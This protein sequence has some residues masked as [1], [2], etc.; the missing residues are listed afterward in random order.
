MPI[1]VPQDLPASE[2]L[3]SEN[4]FV[5]DEER[6]R[7]QDIRPLKLGIINLMPTKISTETQLLRRVSNMALQIHVDLIRTGTYESTHTSREHLQKFY[8]TLEQVKDKK[9]DALIV[10]GA[11]VEH[12]PYEDVAYWDEMVEVM[13]WARRNVFSTMFICWA[14]QAALYH[15]YGIPKYGLDE[16]LFGVFKGYMREDSILTS[17]FDDAFY[18]PHSRVAYNK[19]EDI[20]QIEDLSILVSS[21]EAGA[22]ITATRDNRLI[23]VSGHGEYDETTLEDEYKRDLAK[24]IDIAPPANYY[25]DDDPAKGI[26]KRWTAHSNLLFSNWLNYCV[27][28]ETPFNIEEIT[29]KEI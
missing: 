29:E 2:V 12:M 26:M 6:A 25:H 15:Y 1:V 10:T 8:V 14:A 3:A 4:I 17:G 20:G 19:S 16:K 27:Y 7:R 9:Y 21:E 22:H 13:E 23:F 24:G 11:P 28:Q 18:M 5:M